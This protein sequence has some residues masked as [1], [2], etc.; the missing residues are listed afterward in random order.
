MLETA[1]QPFLFVIQVAQELRRTYLKGFRSVAPRDKTA[2]HTHTRT[3]TFSGR[4][5][6]VPW[7]KKSLKHYPALAVN[8]KHHSS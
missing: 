1:G 3:L 8:S 6:Q 4:R 2:C 5:V 7:A